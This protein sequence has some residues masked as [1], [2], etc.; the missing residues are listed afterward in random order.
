MKNKA[1]TL[2]ELLVVIAII[3]I[4]SSVIYSNITGLR[5]RAKVTAGIRFDSSALHSIGDQLV[6]EWTFD[7]PTN[8]L[9][10][11]SGFNNNAATATVGT[12]PTYSSIGGYNNKGNLSFDGGD[13]V[14]VQNS[15]SMGISGDI[16]ISVWVYRNS[17]SGSVLVHKDA[18]Y[19][20]YITVVDKITWADSSNWSYLNFGYHGNVSNGA[21]HNVAATKSGSKVTIYLDGSVV[22]SK[23]F[24]SAIVS[25]SN[26]TAFGCFSSGGGC[27]TFLD[28]K[29]DDIRI[30][31]SVL[32]SSDIQKLYAEGKDSHNLANK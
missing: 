22:I 10:D 32:S 14:T 26:I 19:S 11:T 1:F 30:Y 6:G 21:W 25:N 23:A 16:T 2:I 17:S 15:S 27:T 8:P 18:N 9:V 28:G 12:S 5:D 13:Y 24:G 20:I 7:I 29:L 4:L 31:S 3:G